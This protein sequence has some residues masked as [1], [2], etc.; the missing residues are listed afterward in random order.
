MA[1]LQ[2]HANDYSEAE[3]DHLEVLK[4]RL[5]ALRP[6]TSSPGSSPRR[7]KDG[8]QSPRRARKEGSQSPSRAIGAEV[9]C[10]VWHGTHQCTGARP[11][12]PP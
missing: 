7:R 12:W 8:S 4:K 3:M 6:G 1:D 5:E 11:P 9:W 10:G 2:K